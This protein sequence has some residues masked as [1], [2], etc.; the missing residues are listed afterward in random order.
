[1]G[2]LLW[3][4]GQPMSFHISRPA[5]NLPAKSEP[6]HG[7]EEADGAVVGGRSDERS[8]HTGDQAGEVESPLATDNVDR[9]APEKGADGE[10]RRGGRKDVGLGAAGNVELLI[11]CDETMIIKERRSWREWRRKSKTGQRR[12]AHRA[13]LRQAQTYKVWRL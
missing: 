2:M 10:S 8:K 6:T 4:K 7:H 9:E 12:A 13:R 5:G 1:M 3:P 11:H